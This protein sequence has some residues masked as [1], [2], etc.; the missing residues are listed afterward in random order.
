MALVE[1][2][3]PDAEIYAIDK[4]ARAL[5]SQERAM[6]SRFPVTTLHQLVADFTRPLALPV[7]DGIVVA[8]AL[9]F[10]RDQDE[11]VRLLRSYLRPSGRLLIVE[12]N[13]EHG[14]LAV[15]YPVPYSRWRSLATQAGFAHTELL[16]KRPSRFLHE[17]YS[18]A[19]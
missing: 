4:D 17:I 9:H 16:T 2:V 19:S 6:R 3:G 12:Y 5:C 14:N 1:L 13:T 11:V 15:P 18:A 10:Q 8:N 7:L